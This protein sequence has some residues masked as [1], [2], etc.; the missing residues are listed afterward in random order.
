MSELR[1]VAIGADLARYYRLSAREPGE[2]NSEKN[3]R[4]RVDV[5]GKFV[6]FWRSSMGLNSLMIA[7]VIVLNISSYLHLISF[8]GF[9][10]SWDMGSP[11]PSMNS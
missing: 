9:S 6:V 1:G 10:F 3:R 4:E 2:S 8:A 5:G 7:W 11:W